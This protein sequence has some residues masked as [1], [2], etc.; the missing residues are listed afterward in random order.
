MI[1]RP[2]NDEA[3]AYYFTYINQVSGDDPAGC[4]GAAARRGADDFSTRSRRRNRSHAMHR[5]SGAS[6][7]CLNHVADTERAF[8]FRALWFSRGFAE[9]LPGF[10]QDISAA[11]VDSDRISWAAHVEEFRTVRLA[12]ISLLRNLPMDSWERRGVA[13]GNPFTV[14]AVAYII[15]GHVAH[16]IGILRERY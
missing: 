1:R 15:P 2:G 10:D 14:R 9:P 12:T 5:R 7:R 4:Y 8:A 11:G 13:S 3:A 6:G 16:H